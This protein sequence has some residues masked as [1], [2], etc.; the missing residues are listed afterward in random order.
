MLFRSNVFNV[1]WSGGV[2][3]LWIDVTNVGT[4]QFTSDR[5]LKDNITAINDNALSRVMQLK[6]VSFN[7]KNIPNTIFI[8]SDIVTEG[9]I[10]D[11]LQQVIP[12]AVNGKKD[13]L[14][15]EGTIQ[16]QTINT[17]PIVSVL[18]KAI[19]EQQQIIEEL[20]RKNNQL[21]ARLISIEERLGK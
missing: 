18:T 20:K 7:Y 14:T 15:S 4:F 19:Q 2:A 11:E 13:A 3:Q 17:A 12:S 21:E 6:P 10:A 5:R 16:P 9:F 8:G 1:N